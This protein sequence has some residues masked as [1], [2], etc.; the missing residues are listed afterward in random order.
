MSRQSISTKSKVFH[1]L[2]NL[3]L[4]LLAYDMYTPSMHS[5]NN[6]QIL[7]SVVPPRALSF[8]LAIARFGLIITSAGNGFELL[9][10]F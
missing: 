3:K 6:K 1:R 8:D 9:S 5:R 2:K 4:H 7:W 10:I